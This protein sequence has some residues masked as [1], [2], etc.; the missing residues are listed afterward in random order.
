MQRCGWVEL[1]GVSTAPVI[2]VLGTGNTELG[3]VASAAQLAAGVT[4]VAIEVV[5]VMKPSH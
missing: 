2:T 1:A 3:S 4:G 5:W